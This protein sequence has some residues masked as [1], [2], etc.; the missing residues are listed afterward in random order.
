MSAPGPSHAAESVPALSCRGQHV[1]KHSNQLQPEA[2]VME[3]AQVVFL[4]PHKAVGGTT[5]QGCAKL[6]DSIAAH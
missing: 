6:V 3:V 1:Q 4:L 2:L 5:R